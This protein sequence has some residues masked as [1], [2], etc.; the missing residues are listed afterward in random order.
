ML[1]IGRQNRPQLYHFSQQRP[2]SLVAEEW[3]LEV[4]ERLDAEGRVQVTLDRD[5]TAELAGKLAG[6]DVESLAIVFLFSFRNPEHEQQAAAIIRERCPELLVSLSSE[7]LP[8]YRE[9]ERT[10]TTVINAYVQPLVARYLRRLEQALASLPCA[11][12]AVQR[13]RNRPFPSCGPG[14]ARRTRAALPAA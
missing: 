12:H 7:I 4:G 11:H 10:A 1:T 6:S 9:Y 8:E 5:R 14:R 2:P 3:R 13:R